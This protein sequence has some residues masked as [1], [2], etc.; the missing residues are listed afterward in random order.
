MNTIKNLKI[1]L[2]L[3]CLALLFANGCV[4][5]PKISTA[6]KKATN[7]NLGY[8]SNLDIEFVWAKVGR[9]QD[10]DS[11]QKIFEKLLKEYK[12]FN[13]FYFGSL[14]FYEDLAK[15]R[16]SDADFA[17]KFWFSEK[18]AD[19]SFLNYSNAFVSFMTLGIIPTYVPYKI[20]LDIELRD[21]REN[22]IIYRYICSESYYKPFAVSYTD[23][24][25]YDDKTPTS[26]IKNL[27]KDALFDLVTNSPLKEF[28]IS[29]N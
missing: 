23:A 13:S 9:V 24:R 10:Y 27:L 25:A 20:T 28:N 6:G 26:T 22:Q 3:I 19:P 21:L 14:Y 18:E 29:G 16:H 8:K 7:L 2:L 17:I 12:F 5:L 15:I 11:Y 1:F 4:S